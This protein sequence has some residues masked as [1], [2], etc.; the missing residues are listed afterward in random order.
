MSMT[1]EQ[2]AEEALGLPSEERAFSGRS[3][4]GEL[5]S[6]RPMVMFVSYGW[7]KP[8]VVEMRCEADWFGRFPEK[9]L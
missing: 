7:L 1:V 5:G 8:C 4:G 6:R 3:T 9:R 2:I